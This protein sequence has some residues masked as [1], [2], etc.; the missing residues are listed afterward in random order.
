MVL[1]KE[2]ENYICEK[3]EY[4][5]RH[6]EE[7][8][9]LQKK[10]QE[11]NETIQDM[12][13]EVQ[14]LRNENTSLGEFLET[15]KMDPGSV[16][17]KCNIMQNNMHLLMDSLNSACIE[18]KKQ[19]MILARDFSHVLRVCKRQNFNMADK[20]TQTDLEFGNESVVSY[21]L[22]MNGFMHDPI[23]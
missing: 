9:N 21:Q 12:M 2:I 4:K 1:K 15:K 8:E 7:L 18:N 16:T 6:Q 5:F 17:Q 23:C 10:V 14:H 13:N 20:S 11:Q 19:D 22:N 3:S